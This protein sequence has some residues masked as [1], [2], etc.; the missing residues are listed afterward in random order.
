[1]VSGNIKSVKLIDSFIDN[2]WLERGLS[3]NTLDAYRQDLS[4]FSNWL[5][6]HG[7]ETADKVK[8]LEI[9]DK[10]NIPYPE[11]YCLDKKES[12]TYKFPLKMNQVK[13]R[14]NGARVISVWD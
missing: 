7:L 13:R 5:E 10:C 9:A 14:R 2:I 4:N 12:V 1:M 3:Q 6:P 11:T 8:L